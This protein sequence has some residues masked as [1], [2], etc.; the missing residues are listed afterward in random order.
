MTN[1]KLIMSLRC[2]GKMIQENGEG[3]IS[4]K[5]EITRDFLEFYQNQRVPI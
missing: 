2:S 1:T 5:Q 3:V 4:Q